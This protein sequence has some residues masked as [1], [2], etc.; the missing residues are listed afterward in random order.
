MTAARSV[1]K[2][3]KLLKSMW[4][5]IEDAMIYIKNRI[6]ISSESDEEAI[7]FF[8]NVNG[9]SSNILN[10]RALNCR[11]Y[12][13]VF[14]TFNRHKPN[15]RCWKD[16]YVGY[17]KNNQWKIYNFCIRTV[18]LTKDMKFNEKSI[19]YDE[20]INASQDFEDLDNK[21]EIKEFWNSEDDSL[22]NVHSRRNWFSKSEKIQILMTSESLSKNGNG[23]GNMNKEIEEEE[24]FVDATDL[25][26]S[27]LFT[28][29][30]SKNVMSASQQTQSMREP[31]SD[32]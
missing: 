4:D 6:I 13:H 23:D 9:V 27:F 28:N 21:S 32:E 30:I 10:L 1:L 20:D 16:I 14:K 29:V 18:H 17:D 22:L 24:N 31:F 2:V 25:Q 11:V 12:T 8:E 19:F 15:D 5:V 26:S 3:M 7:T